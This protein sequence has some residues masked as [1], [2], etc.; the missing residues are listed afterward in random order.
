[1]SGPKCNC[2]TMHRH[3]KTHRRKCSDI[4]M[5]FFTFPSTCLQ[6]KHTYYTDNY[7]QYIHQYDR[8]S[9]SKDDGYNDNEK[10]HTLSH[11]EIIKS[12]SE[13]RVL[14]IISMSS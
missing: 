12:I 13:E 8:L 4:V 7:C 10:T 1:M 14:N 3:S 5:K 11:T 6:Y 9:H 2:A